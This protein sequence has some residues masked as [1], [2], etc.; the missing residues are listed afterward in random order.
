MISGCKQ[1]GSDGFSDLDT[2]TLAEV[3]EF[4]FRSRPGDQPVYRAELWSSNKGVEE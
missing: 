2:H 1:A 4:F 3:P